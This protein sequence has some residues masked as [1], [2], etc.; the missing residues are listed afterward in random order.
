MDPLPHRDTATIAGEFDAIAR[1]LAASTLPDRLT[2]AERHVVERVPAAARRVLDAGCG[3]GAVSRALARR[4]ASVLGL[5]VSPAMVE[6][7][8]ARV[9]GD[10]RLE[11]RIADLANEPL[12]DGAFDAVV[13]VATVHHLPLA[14][15]VPRL[16]AAV[17]PGGVLLVQ[18]VMTRH[19]PLDLPW[20]LA[21]A[22]M[23][24]LRAL[25]G[26]APPRALRDA[27][28]AHGAGERYLDA[29]EVAPAYRALLP[30]A[31]MRLHLEWRYTVE[32]RRPG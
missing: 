11:Y 6:L 3:A 21:A 32:W 7:A 24:R 14:S 17:A 29:R 4:G 26:D 22:A 19:S 23:R 27:Y 30:G 13:S 5:D 16:A 1:V 31:T 12:P 9:G 8:R 28:N 25:G 10:A 20:A 15:I 18:D 2:A